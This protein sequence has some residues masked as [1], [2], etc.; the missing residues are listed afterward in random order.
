MV[1]DSQDSTPRVQ[2]RGTVRKLDPLLAGLMLA[3]SLTTA[4]VV[5]AP[6]VSPLQHLVSSSPATARAKLLPVTL[7]ADITPT[8]RLSDLVDFSVLEQVQIEL[9][10]SLPP[11]KTGM[12]MGEGADV[13]IFINR[14]YPLF[15]QYSTLTHELLHARDRQAHMHRRLSWAERESRALAAELSPGNLSRIRKLAAMEK[16]L[17]S[18]A[19]KAFLRDVASQY[20]FYRRFAAIERRKQRAAEARE[21]LMY[22]VP[23]PRGRSP[24]FY[25][26][27]A[28]LQAD[29]HAAF[30]T[31]QTKRILPVRGRRPSFAGTSHRTVPMFSD[32]GLR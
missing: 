17:G 29:A 15:I 19:L 27:L 21:T 2:G 31:S 23:R 3:A 14:R 28:W 6:V 22:P 5:A 30:P 10:D 13:R 12:T 18:N 25:A 8:T 24:G 4:T 7:D 16:N 20:R 9:V 11:D 26:P 1:T 32:G